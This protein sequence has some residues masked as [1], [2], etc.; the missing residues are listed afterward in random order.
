MFVVWVYSAT[1]S[2]SFNYISITILNTYSH[3]DR[4]LGCAFKACAK[5]NDILRPF[6][7]P[8]AQENIPKLNEVTENDTIKKSPLKTNSSTF[9]PIK[10]NPRWTVVNGNGNIALRQ[11]HYIDFKCKN[12]MGVH[13]IRIS[14][15]NC[16]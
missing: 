16:F 14:Q 5:I 7:I 13:V 2:I 3:T 10:S 9:N 12:G 15:V 11:T 4:H 1:P 8:R 6:S